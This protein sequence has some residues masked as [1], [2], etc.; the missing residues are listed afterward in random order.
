MIQGKSLGTIKLYRLRTAASLRAGRDQDFSTIG[1][2]CSVRVCTRR[3]GPARASGHA[4]PSTWR[5]A[6]A[7]RL[8]LTWLCSP[9][10]GHPERVEARPLA[11]AQ[12]SPGLVSE[13]GGCWAALSHGR[14]L[15]V[16]SMLRGTGHWEPQEDPQAAG[17]PERASVWFLGNALSICI[18]PGVLGTAW[19]GA[20]RCGRRGPEGRA[21]P[22]PDSGEEP[23]LGRHRGVRKRG[24]ETC[25][26]VCTHVHAYGHT[27]VH[28]RAVST[29]TLACT[30]VHVA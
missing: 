10:P 3:V 12:S 16:G 2:V 7:A 21:G 25:A 17:T 18:G 4:G 15:R 29:G 24:L 20:Y 6:E 9:S 30:P 28:T 5:L 14:R 8:P 11:G 22:Y 1:V 26:H 23:P 13:A 27:H 19:P